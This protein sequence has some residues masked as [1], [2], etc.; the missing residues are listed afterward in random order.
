[1]I[2]KSH[3]SAYIWWKKTVIQKDICIQC[4]LQYYLQ[5]PR[6]GCYLMSIDRGIDKEDVV[7]ILAIKKNEIMSVAPTLMDIEIVRW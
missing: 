7:W 6:P 4:S 5:Q 1:M 3:F 2:Q